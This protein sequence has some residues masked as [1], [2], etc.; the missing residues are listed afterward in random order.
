[1]G[2]GAPVTAPTES[3]EAATRRPARPVA[4]VGEVLNRQADDAKAISGAR[5][6]AWNGNVGWLPRAGRRE[7]RS[8]V[9]LAD[10]DGTVYF[11]RDYVLRPLQ[12]LFEKAG[13]G[14]VPAWELCRA[15]NAL[16]VVLH[17]NCHL[18]ATDPADHAA[19]KDRWN[20]P[21]VVLEEGATEAFSQ[22]QLNA[23]VR[24]LGLDRVAPSLAE[25]ETEA[26]Y[27]LFVPAVQVLTQGVG[28]LSQQPGSEVLRKLVCEAG[29][30]KFETLGG[31]V[32]QGTGLAARMPEA[33]R[34]AATEEIAGATRDVLGEVAQMGPLL[35]REASQ[36]LSRRVG[37]EALRGILVQ[38]EELDQRYPKAGVPEG[39]SRA[40]V[41]PRGMGRSASGRRHPT[42]DP[43]AARS[44]AGLTR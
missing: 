19:T 26:T 6:S 11:D 10:W 22:A 24:R 31:I 14:E 9:G 34:G 28:R 36:N 1:L 12:A 7:P 44:A 29:G 43:D 17:E 25:L 39:M 42:I 21:L 37:R 5:S 4:S 33:D 27:P 16:A 40:G 20:W 13:S 38:L 41:L 35:T 2:R 3:P 18:L 32:L 30:K 23:Y 8:A 15:K